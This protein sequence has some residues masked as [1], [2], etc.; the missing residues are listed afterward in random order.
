[1]CL[2]ADQRDKRCPGQTALR[3][4]PS[5]G[6]EDDHRVPCRSWRRAGYQDRQGGRTPI[7]VASVSEARARGPGGTGAWHTVALLRSGNQVITGRAG[8]PGRPMC[9]PSGLPVTGQTLLKVCTTSPGSDDICLAVCTV[10]AG[11]RRIPHDFAPNHGSLIS[12][13]AGGTRE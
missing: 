3:T 1:V 7:D 13:F 11:W 2:E 6:R 10:A 4:S 9:R 5:A 8:L 12:S